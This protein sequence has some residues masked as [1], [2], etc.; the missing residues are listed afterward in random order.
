MLLLLYIDG[1]RDPLT[2]YYLLFGLI[3]PE[4]NFL[5]IG[6]DQN[7]TRRMIFMMGEKGYDPACDRIEIFFP[8]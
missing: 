5:S 4:S 7:Q 3:Y 1:T 2:M 6:I 8:Q